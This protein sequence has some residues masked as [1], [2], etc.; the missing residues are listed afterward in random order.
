MQR[1]KRQA[2][3]IVV[4]LA[5]LAAGASLA[6]AAD[7]VQSRV[8]KGDWASED[9]LWAP[10][11]ALRAY[12]RAVAQVEVQE[13]GAAEMPAATVLR[14]LGAVP[15]R[16]RVSLD[17]RSLSEITLRPGQ[18][19]LLPHT[20]VLAGLTVEWLNLWATPQDDLTTRYRAVYRGGRRLWLPQTKE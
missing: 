1:S 18:E 3:I 2:V 4:L 11:E 7:A 9:T 8:G 5:A 20:Q 14:N 19:Y 13:S 6:Q 17:G 16:A 10:Q 15:L 12:V